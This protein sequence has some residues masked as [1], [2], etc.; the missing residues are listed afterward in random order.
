MSFAILA[1]LTIALGLFIALPIYAH[2]VR[3]EPKEQLYFGAMMLLRR[4]EKTKK[5]RSRLHDL[6]LLLLRIVALIAF[7]LSLSQMELQWPNVDTTTEVSKRVVIIIDNS[8]S[9]NHIFSD[10]ETALTEAKSRAIENLQTFPTGVEV[11]IIEGGFPAQTISTGEV[12]GCNS[13]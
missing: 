13:V 11:A 7:I 8:M 5:R 12:T 3:R 4:L 10:D 9:M 2:L 6:L 1:P